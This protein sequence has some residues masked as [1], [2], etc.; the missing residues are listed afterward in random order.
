MEGVIQ[1]GPLM[2]ATERAAA[3]A[4]FWAFLSI[5]AVIGARTATRVGRVAWIALAAGL[6]ASRIGFV[7]ANAQAFA[8]EPWSVLAVWQGGFSLWPGVAAAA[9]VIVVMLRRQRATLWLGATLGALVA[10][11]LTAASQLAPAPRPLPDG[12]ILADMKLNPVA[13]DSLHGRPMVLNLWATWCP[14]CRREMPMLVDVA[15]GSKTPILLVNQ[16][17]DVAQVRAYLQRAGLAEA[18][19]RLDPRGIVGQ[20]LGA[21]AMPTTLFIDVE[22]RIRRTHS[23]EISRAALISALRELEETK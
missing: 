15:K 17:E 12:L 6:T 4:L 22:G 23:G 9:V 7:V 13:L 18:S 19:A 21:R 1:I 16:G 2:I 8:A 20:R 5:G 10:V 14:P 11:H 3:L